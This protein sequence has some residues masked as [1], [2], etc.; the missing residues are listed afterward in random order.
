MGLERTAA[1]L[2]GVETNFHIDILRPLVEAAGEVCGVKY[3]PASEN[4]RRLRRIADHV[5]ACTFAIHENVYPGH[6]TSRN[7]SSAGCSAARCST[8]TRWASTSRSSI[9]LVPV[10]AELMKRPYPELSRDGRARVAR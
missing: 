2:Q 3:D 6:R 8:A 10:V 1:V 5:R 9:K 4:G 7:T